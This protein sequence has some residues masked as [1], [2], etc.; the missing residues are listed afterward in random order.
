MRRA[1]ALGIAVLLTLALGA[2]GCG[3]VD[4]LTPFGIGH[5][6][7]SSEGY[8]VNGLWVGTVDSG[9]AVTFQVGNAEINELLLQY[10]TDVCTIDFGGTTGP[11][12]IVDGEFT[13]ERDLT[14]LDQGRIVITGRF[15]SSNTCV[16]SFSFEGLP[17]SSCPTSGAGSFSAEKFL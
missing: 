3:L 12:P 13:I 6:D 1:G 4:S 8:N 9:G 11:V 15:T 5:R 16:G 2:H 17:A 10:V 7:Y 14:S